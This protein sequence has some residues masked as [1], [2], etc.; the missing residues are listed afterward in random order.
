MKTLAPTTAATLLDAC[1]EN[2]GGVSTLAVS[3]LGYAY[4]YFYLSPTGGS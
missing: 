1:V 2:T 3:Y 4:F